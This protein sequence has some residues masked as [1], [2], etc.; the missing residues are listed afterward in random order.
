MVDLNKIV[1]FVDYFK[2]ESTL[3]VISIGA[4]ILVPASLVILGYLS[5]DQ[6]LPLTLGLVFIS[7]AIP[8]L[9]SSSALY[10]S[11][12]ET[13]SPKGYTEQEEKK[14]KFGVAWIIRE[15]YESGSM[16]PKRIT[17]IGPICPF[18]STGLE[19]RRRYLFDMIKITNEWKCISCEKKYPRPEKTN[20]EIKQIIRS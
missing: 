7:I 11:L 20:Q 15:L 16:W 19:T 8:R 18:C 10:V 9:V 6:Q 12:P 14:E 2:R 3:L 13:M 1:G 5:K 17:I 4:S